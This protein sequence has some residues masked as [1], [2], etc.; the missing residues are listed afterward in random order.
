MSLQTPTTAEISANIIA[1]LEATLNQ[2]IPLL[3]KSFLRVLSKA[4]GAVFILLYKYGGFMFLQMFVAT[5]QNKDTIV[6]G[7]VINPLVFWGR[8]IGIGDPVAATQAELLIDV[9]VENQTGSLPSGSQLINA[10][11]GVTYITIGAVLLDAAT[12]QATIRA[13][14]DQTDGGGAGAIGN[15]EPADIVSFANP[16]PNVARDA[17]V[18]SQIVTGADAESTAAYRQRVI[19]RFQA[20]PQGGAYAD[21]RIWGE[22]VAGII[23]IYPYTGDPG[24]VDVYAE[25]TVASSGSAD[26]I[27]T[28]A[29]LTAV[30]DSI[31][32]DDN[33]LASRRPANA[34]VNV[35]AITRSGFDTVVD[36]LVVDNIA[37]VQAD[38]EAALIQYYLAA[39]P[40]VD[41]LTIPPRKDRITNS[42]ITGLVEDIVTAANGVFTGVTFD[43][44]GVGGSLSLYILQQGEKAKSATVGVSYT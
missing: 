18:D 5:A 28:G 42:A 32:L 29:Q 19:D 21:Y 22:E 35:I 10:D 39:E 12:V 27:P 43:V 16:L 15:L 1:Q 9:T 8:L 24:E 13:V 30:A 11:N 36:G 34:F 3:P 20:R 2:T 14:A 26:G 33:G 38:I 23:N 31:E 41:G 7:T 4:L 17:V 6:N 37:Q 44:T 40:F 25:A